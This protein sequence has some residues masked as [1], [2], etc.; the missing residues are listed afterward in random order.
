MKRPIL[1]TAFLFLLLACQEKE[2]QGLTQIK[3]VL[4]Q[5]KSTQQEE[6]KGQ[7]VANKLANT[8]P[9]NEDQLRDAFPKRINDL[10]VDDRITVIGQ[11]IIGN[12]GNHKITLSVMDASGINSQAAA[13]FLD[14]Y[15]YNKDE[16]S[17]GFKII[18]KERNGIKTTSD[19]YT[20][21]EQSEIRFLFRDR[22]YITLA[23]NNTLIQM[24]PDSSG[25]PL[26]SMF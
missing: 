2:K 18:R 21:Q 5:T 22:Y 19:Y 16:F 26:M 6:S 25:I 11:Q 15:S 20:T 24:T 9:L 14:S 1:I 10:A 8:I 13:H 17:E 3:Q 23:N 12:F 4:N 7:I